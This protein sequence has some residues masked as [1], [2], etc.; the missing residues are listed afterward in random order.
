MPDQLSAKE[1]EKYLNRDDALIDVNV[2]VFRDVNTRGY[3]AILRSHN[4]GQTPLTSIIK[5]KTSTTTDQVIWNGFVGA[6]IK[7]MTSRLNAVYQ[8]LKMNSDMQAYL[9]NLRSRRKSK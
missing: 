5:T 6:V 8:S 4:Q 2:T 7:I 3:V 9:T 1:L